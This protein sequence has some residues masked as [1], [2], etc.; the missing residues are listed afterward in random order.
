MTHSNGLVFSQ[1]EV[2][3][4]KSR[5]TIDVDHDSTIAIYTIANY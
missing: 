2:S 4:K 1:K 5:D 3:Y